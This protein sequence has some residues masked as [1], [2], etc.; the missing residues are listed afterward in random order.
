MTDKHTYLKP[1]D[2]QIKT[3]EKFEDLAPKDKLIYL[4]SLGLLAP[5]S[6]NTIPER[7]K[8]DGDNFAITICLDHKNVLPQSDKIGRQAM[9]SLGCVVQT[10]VLAAKDYNLETNLEFLRDDNFK[11]TPRNDISKIVKLTFAKSSYNEG[12]VWSP[13]ILKRKVVRAEYDKSIKLSTDQ[14]SQI[15]QICLNLDSFLRLD[16]ISDS[17]T[18]TVLS[19]FQELAD[20]IVI[21]NDSF[22][23]ELGLWLWPNS[24]TT[25]TTGMR[26]I[27]F[28]ANDSYSQRI[29]DGLNRKINLLPDEVAGFAATGALGIKTSSAVA[30]IGVE[31]DN[32]KSWLSAGRTYLQIAL[33]LEKDEFVTAMHAGITEIE[34]PNRMLKSRLKSTHRPTVVFRIGKPRNPED[35]NRPHS[36]RPKVEELLLN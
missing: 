23:R 28:G 33:T 13:L 18:L 17:P 26:G 4:C 30:V 32:W 5:T 12:I 35:L 16:L 14:I 29:H 22:A 6:H 15:S 27:E 7:F 11:P 9:V 24:D 2:L 10:L 34:I 19:K 31:K 3:Q 21:E 25:H 1:W 36:A 20:R 8:I